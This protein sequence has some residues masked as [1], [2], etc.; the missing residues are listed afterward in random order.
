M[1]TNKFGFATLQDAY[2]IKEF[3]SEQVESY[4]IEEP[5]KQPAIVIETFDEE[6][7]VSCESVKEHCEK[8]KQ[9][10]SHGKNRMKLNEFLNIILILLLIYII[11]FRRN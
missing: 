1:T 8:C 9:C 4:K 5:S 6:S 11:F 2:G 7:D 3:Q 10:G